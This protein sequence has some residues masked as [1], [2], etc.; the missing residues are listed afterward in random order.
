MQRS[1][2]GTSLAPDLF[3]DP[4]PLD[5]APDLPLPGGFERGPR[6]LGYL[7]VVSLGFAPWC[8]ACLS[9]KASMWYLIQWTSTIGG[10]G[11]RHSA[12][13]S[14]SRLGGS[15]EVQRERTQL[16]C[17]QG[18]RELRRGD[19]RCV[20]AGGLRGEGVWECP[21]PFQ[22]LSVCLKATTKT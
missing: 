20:P 4:T 7:A 10:W 15:T 13:S 14:E 3:P 9:L 16:L 22:W 6:V 21:F 19:A 8:H 1:L 17:P 5:Q 12:G 11:G 2:L 18:C